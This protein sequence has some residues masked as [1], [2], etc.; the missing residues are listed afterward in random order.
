MPTYTGTDANNSWTVI[1][2]GNFTLDGLGGKDTLALGTSLRSAY[3]ITQGSDGAVHID[4]VSGASQQLHATLYNME[5]LT[6]NSGRDVLDLIAFFGDK[7][8]PAVTIS[9]NI[10]G[11]ANTNVTYTLRFSESVVGL[12]AA[13]FQVGN[14]S[15]VSVA[16][17]GSTWTVVVA[18]RAGT[19]GTLGLA[20]VAA[21]VTDAAGN[22]N[23]AAAAAPQAIDTLAPSL[24]AASPAS[25]ASGV[26]LGSNIDFIF[27]E[28]IQKAAGTIV[29]GTAEGG[30]LASYNVASSPNVTVSGRTL[31][32]DPSTDLPASSSLRVTLSAGAVNDAAGNALASAATGSFTTQADPRYTGGS[33]NDVFAGTAGHHLVA[34]GDGVDTLVLAQPR[35]AFTTRLGGGTTTVTALDGSSSF[36]LR[37]TERIRFSDINLALDLAGH[38]GQAAKVIGAV[39]GAAAVANAEYVGIGLQLLDSG[40]PYET[41][42]QLALKVVLGNNPSD[43]AVVEL[44]YRNVI[45]NEPS[46]AMES[47]FVGLL[48]DRGLSQSA[49]AVLAADTA[50]NQMHIQL[51]GLA[52]SG[53]PYLGA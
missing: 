53:L 41:L 29:V 32:L 34:G 4:S 49:L 7:V 36:E 24:A 26:A 13:D 51:V 19:E 23:A 21:G 48:A 11:I 1:N 50:E 12:T 16:G 28:A 30:V 38:A 3:Q 42:M 44:L 40:T 18:P 35:S 39:F 10:P 43:E 9:D 17:S 2:P 25:L 5:V 22:P 14:G 6:F 46:A 47:Y 15:V 8:P 20:L 27:S 31:T 52:D 33:G 37:A 45:G